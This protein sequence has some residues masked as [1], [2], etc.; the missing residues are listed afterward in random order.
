MQRSCSA[1]LRQDRRINAWANPPKTVA[2]TDHNPTPRSANEEKYPVRLI[3]FRDLDRVWY[4]V[5]ET[6]FNKVGYITRKDTVIHPRWNRGLTETPLSRVKRHLHRLSQRLARTQTEVDNIEAFFTQ[7]TLSVELFNSGFQ[8]IISA[9]D[10]S[11][12]E[13]PVRIPILDDISPQ[14][15]ERRWETFSL[16]LRRADIIFVLDTKSLISRL[17]ARFDHGTWGHVGTYT[18]DGTIV[19][20]IKDGVVERDIEVY[21]N[22]RYRLGIYRH[23]NLD[24]KTAEDLVSFMRSQL[25]KRYNFRGVARLALLKVLGLQPGKGLRPLR[26]DDLTPNDLARSERV[27]LLWVV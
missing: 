22:P 4:R 1:V 8:A 20:A 23:T 2:L 16:T 15:F 11:F 5:D 3:T 12:F 26:A 25:G 18:G 13:N 19:E 21:R 7:N 10:L 6:R 24:P 27:A 9:S 14:E 17:I